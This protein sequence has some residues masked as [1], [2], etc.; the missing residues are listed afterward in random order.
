L[1]LPHFEKR[2]R[3]PLQHARRALGVGGALRPL[4]LA[5]ALDPRQVL[6]KLALQPLRDGETVGRLG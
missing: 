5:H 1:Q 4:H 3:Q 2:R 6:F